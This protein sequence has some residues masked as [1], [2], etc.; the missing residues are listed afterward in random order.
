[1]RDTGRTR[2]GELLSEYVLHDLSLERNTRVTGV[3]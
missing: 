3:E 2:H 1:M